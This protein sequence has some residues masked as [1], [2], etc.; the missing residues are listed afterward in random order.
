MTDIGTLRGWLDLRLPSLVL[1]K[2]P[3]ANSFDILRSG[4]HGLIAIG[5]KIGHEYG[6]VVGHPAH[7][8][9]ATQSALR[10]LDEGCH[11][12]TGHAKCVDLGTSG[13]DD[14]NSPITLEPEGEVVG[15]AGIAI[16]HPPAK[17]TRVGRVAISVVGQRARENPLH[18]WKVI[19]CRRTDVPGQRIS[20]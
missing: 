3:P 14:E 1:R 18:Q 20:L 10:P 12:M 8:A 11:R 13:V 4:R 9:F 17:L 2:S 16:K 15:I 5:L 6:V 19:G 7:L